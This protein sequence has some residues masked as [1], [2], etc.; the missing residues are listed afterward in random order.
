MA[1]DALT[2]V[3]AEDGVPPPDAS[4]LLAA[5]RDGRVSASD[6][7][8][9]HL[10]RLAAVQPTINAAVEVFADRARAEAAQPR[11]GA[12]SGLPISIKETFALSGC[13]ITAGSRVM[14]PVDCQ[15][16]AVAVRRLRDA[17]AIVLARGNVP[18]FAMAAET[19]NPRFGR[20]ANPLAPAH[21]CGGSSGGDAAL[22]AAG[23]V[24]AGLGS[25]ILG[26]IRI[27][28]AFCG[29]VGF[30]PASQAVPK[31]GM[32]PEIP[33]LYADS[34]L[35]AGPLARSVR[36]VRLI[37]S[38]I[39]DEPP[40]PPGSLRG[41]RLVVP[42]G[43]P[44]DSRDAVIPV[45]VAAAAAHLRECG[46]VEER[47]DLGDV[48]DWYRTMGGLLGY[49]LLPELRRGLSSA[50]GRRFSVTRESLRRS[51]GRGRLYGGLYRLLLLAPMLRYRRAET[52]R[53]G[54]ARIE[55]AR[56]RVRE[57]LG[58]DGVLLLPTL[59]TLAPRHGEMNRLS[60]RPGL[61]RM[62]APTSLCNY[63]DL[64]AVSVPAWRYRDPTTGLVPGVMLA[65]APGAEGALLDAAAALETGL[66]GE[67]NE[68]EVSG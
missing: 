27:P 16:D 12:L 31:A 55:A 24:A 50:D 68:P 19:E 9:R 34:W 57:L 67:P 11:P 62:L 2:V 43:F 45:A 40:P 48:R 15:E 64:P 41:L 63:L 44:W 47:R 4:A 61:N 60:F 59:G 38:V 26:S 49:E 1:A 36:D 53:R 35:A 54:I 66:A 51:V 22:V 5:I 28:A 23:C 30:K 17:G 46:L 20:S 3:A 65:A 39:A 32:W 8:E 25:D 10:E 37:Y 13:R 6:L 7:V 58:H 42:E 18:E 14:A 21:T 56:R 52:V 29:L 33:A